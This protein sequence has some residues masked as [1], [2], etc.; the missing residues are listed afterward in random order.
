[1]I[2][3]YFN[4][5]FSRNTIRS[6][7]DMTCCMSTV[8][9]KVGMLCPLF[10]TQI[11]FSRWNN[12]FLVNIVNGYAEIQEWILCAIQRKTE[13]N[14][15]RY[16]THLWKPNVCI[17][18]TLCWSWLVTSSTKYRYALV[19]KT[20]TQFSTDT[21]LLIIMDYYREDLQCV[22]WGTDKFV[23]WTL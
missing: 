7:L 13:R 19:T 4:V 1:M 5:Y 2:W 20:N 22:G 23:S 11:S 8:L 18:P 10:P 6:S 17:I 15:Y 12:L 9:C 3:S 14:S 16:C 21:F